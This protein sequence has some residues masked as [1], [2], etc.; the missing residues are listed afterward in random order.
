MKKLFDA[1]EVV[2]VGEV[3]AIVDTVGE[4]EITTSKTEEAVI[5][6]NPEVTAVQVE[7]QVAQIHGFVQLVLQLALQ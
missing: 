6:P 3:F 5:V 7:E 1:D 2:K 4:A